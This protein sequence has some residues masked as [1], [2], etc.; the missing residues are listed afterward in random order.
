MEIQQ[1]VAGAGLDSATVMHV[2]AERSKGLTRASGAVIESL[3]QEELV[4]QVSVGTEPLRLK[5]DTSLSGLAIRTG[6]LQR[7]DDVS[8]DTRI[9]HSGYQAV[10]I[11]SL[12]VVPLRDNERTLGTLKVVS[13]QANAFSDRDAKALRLLGASPARPWATPQPTRD[14]RHAS[15]IGPG[16]YR[17][18]S[19]GSS[20]WW[21]SR[22]RGSGSPTIAG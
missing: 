22:R 20:N 8:S 15:K 16:R 11:R 9:G 13:P 21:T 19:S 7:S 3:Q 18:V 5:M 12:L 17:T 6:E 10:G 14:V 1:A 2:I 4:P